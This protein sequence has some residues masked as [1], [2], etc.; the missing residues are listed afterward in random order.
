RNE[1]GKELI[2]SVTRNLLADTPSLP[3]DQ[4][5]LRGVDSIQFSCYDGL[6]W[7]DAWDSTTLTNLPQAVRVRIQMVDTTGGSA[8]PL[9]MLVPI[10]S[11]T[12]TNQPTASTTGA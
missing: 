3:E 2:R 12:L 7:Y 9:E 1:P 6:T 11:Q 10:D 5:L 4:F 8:R